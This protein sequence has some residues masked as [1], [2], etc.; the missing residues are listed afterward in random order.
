V[1]L[2]LGVMVVAR[3][4]IVDPRPDLEDKDV[5]PREEEGQGVQ[6]GVEFVGAEVHLIIL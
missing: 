1:L 4:A 5:R 6:D 3:Q 2:L